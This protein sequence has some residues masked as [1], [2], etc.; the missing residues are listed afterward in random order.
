MVGVILA[1]GQGT[2]MAPFSNRLP[3]PILP[4]CNRPL[5]D[6]QLETMREAGIGECF[7]VVGHL[8]YEISLAIGSGAHRGMRIHYVEQAQTLGI[9][10]ALGQLQPHVRSPFLLFLGDIFFCTSGL[11]EMVERFRQRE[12]GSVLVVREDE[13]EAIQKNFAVVV[14]PATGH[15]RRVIEKPRYLHNNLK[16]CGL[17][18]FDLTIFDAVRRTPRTAMRDE[19]EL[20][21]AIQILIEDGEPVELAMVVQEDINLTT[22]VDLHRCNMLQLD[23]LGLERLV[24]PGAAVDPRAT[25]RRTVVGAGARIR[26]PVTLES[27]VV[28]P[29][30]IVDGPGD[31][32]RNYIITPG[33]AV[34]CQA[35]AVAPAR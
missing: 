4:V 3:K 24:D 27:C 18:L 13:P 10:H 22:P 20:T 9:A 1:G 34:D 14:D 31:V 16:G 35:L 7:V 30:A 15:V 33:A 19:Y 21:D 25:L 26:G 23:R 12:Q 6:Y 28:F 8:G 29:N 5:L 11:A 32:I 2:R 17:Y